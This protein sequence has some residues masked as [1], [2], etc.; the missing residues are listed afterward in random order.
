MLKILLKK[1]RSYPKGKSG[2]KSVNNLKDNEFYTEWQEIQ[3]AIESIFI[4]SLKISFD[5]KLSSTNLPFKKIYTISRCV[6]FLLLIIQYG[7]F[8]SRYEVFQL[9]QKGKSLLFILK[10][11]V[12]K[13]RAEN[14]PLCLCGIKYFN[15]AKCFDDS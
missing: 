2:M 5:I 3:L 15:Q 12:P 6:P 11:F 1:Y 7:V 13:P 9:D 14:G 10:D 4:H 8:S